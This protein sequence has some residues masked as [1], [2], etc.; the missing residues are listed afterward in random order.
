MAGLRVPKLSQSSAGEPGVAAT[1]MSGAVA[2][3][4]GGESVSDPAELELRQAA[5]GVFSFHGQILRRGV[6][7][8]S[9]ACHGAVL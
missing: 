7:V 3:F 6:V 9:H 1:G 8:R 5:R 2:C 4:G